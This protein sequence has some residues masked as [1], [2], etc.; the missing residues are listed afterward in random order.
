MK[1]NVYV[2]FFFVFF[3]LFF[4]DYFS[5]NNLVLKK[6]KIVRDKK[7]NKKIIY[8]ILYNPQ[9]KKILTQSILYGDLILYKK[10]NEEKIVIFY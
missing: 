10:I 3:F 5:S 2:K 7:G 1:D 4:L 6:N 8:F 9:Y